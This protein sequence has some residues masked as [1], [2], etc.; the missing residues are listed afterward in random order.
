MKVLAKN[1][2]AAFDYELAER[3]TAGLVLSGAEVKS[4]KA[5]HASLKGAFVTLRNGEAWLNNTHVTPYQPS[6]RLIQPDPTRIRKLLL[7]R[8]QLDRLID[9]RRTGL[10]LVP[11]ALLLDGKL[12]KLELALGQSKKR[13]DKRETMKR[14]DSSRDAAREVAKFSRKSA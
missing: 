5:G 2:R 1:R 3:I 10:S 9:E 7:H 14:R 4:I 13:Y 12:I 6:G 11:T 8:K